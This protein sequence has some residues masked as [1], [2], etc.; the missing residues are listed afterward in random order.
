VLQLD[1]HRRVLALPSG[2]RRCLLVGARLTD[3][4]LRVRFA[5][6]PELWPQ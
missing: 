4:V 1:G 6:D 2:L 3:G 5:P